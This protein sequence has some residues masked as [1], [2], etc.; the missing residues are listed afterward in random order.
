[1]E[2]LRPG[3]PDQIG[4]YQIINR[5]GA[6]GM[7]VVYMGTTGTRSAAIK[8]VRDYL[9]EDPAS[10]T[11]LS[12]EVNALKKVKSPFVAEIID[13]DIDAERAWIATNYVDGP[14]LKT[15][16]ENEGVLSEQKWFEF[17]HGL[18]S[19]LAAVHAAGIVHRDVKPSNIL[20][21]ASGPRLI[22][23][24]IA[25]SNDATA[26]TKTG[27]VAGTP[28]WFAPEQFHTNKITNAVDMFSAGSILYF[29]ATGVSPW[30]KEDTSVATTMN[31]ILTK[32]PDLNQLTPAQRRLIEPLLIKEPKD[33]YTASQ[34]LS[35][36]QEIKASTG[37]YF[38]EPNAQKKNSRKS[39]YV[40]AS[41]IVL[42]LGGALGYTQIASS[43]KEVQTEPPAPII[44]KWSIQVEGENKPQTGTGT[45]FEFF[46]CDQ[47]VLKDSLKIREITLPAAKES[48]TTKVITNDKRCGQNFDTIIISGELQ[49]G[50]DERQYVLAGSTST[51]FLL[52]YNFTIKE[53]IA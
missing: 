35:L 52:Q 47:S 7:G 20:M 2:R 13:S 44:K 15:L 9:L 12:R 27:M 51:G 4:P 39:F 43:G 8:I 14:S 33:R 22:D 3:D 30:G 25:F 32:V 48:P 42:V 26:V 17:A 31:A 50:K 38:A 45:K 10:R 37:I 53:V 21:S 36:M 23:F 41:L 24:G 1:M 6:G 34:A 40:A 5:L 49:S 29:A 46:V 19:A 11:R 18:I 16:I 28:T